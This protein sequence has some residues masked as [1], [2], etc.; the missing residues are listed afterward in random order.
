MSSAGPW[1]TAFMEMPATASETVPNGSE[2]PGPGG[3][4][5][6]MDCV[7]GRAGSVAVPP[8]FANTAAPETALEG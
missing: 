3:C 4:Q 8:E 2:N 1:T 7:S 6:E 5:G